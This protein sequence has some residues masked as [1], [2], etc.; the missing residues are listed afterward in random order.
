MSVTRRRSSAQV[1]GERDL[2]SVLHRS[3]CPAGFPERGFA[4]LDRLGTSIAD[5]IAGPHDRSSDVRSCDDNR[6]RQY[7]SCPVSGAQERHGLD[8][9]RGILWGPSGWTSVANIW[10]LTMSMGIGIEGRFDAPCEED[11]TRQAT[12]N[13][14]RCSMLLRLQVSITP[15]AGVD[16]SY[17]LNTRNKIHN[18]LH[19]ERLEARSAEDWGRTFEVAEDR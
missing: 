17:K 2:Q 14:S 15:G 16:T 18:S 9:L 12:W 7:R 13:R 5:S 8:R 1:T 19:S 11:P 3:T 4:N 10:Q 6:G